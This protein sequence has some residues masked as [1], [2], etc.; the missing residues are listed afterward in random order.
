[1]NSSNS[2][3]SILSQILMELILDCQNMLSKHFAHF[4]MLIKYKEAN[5]LYCTKRNRKKWRPSLKLAAKEILFS[6]I[7]WNFRRFLVRSEFVC[8]FALV[9]P[10]SG[11]FDARQNQSVPVATMVQ[12]SLIVRHGRSIFE[13]SHFGSGWSM[14]NTNDLGLVVFV[15]VDKC[16]FLF[17]LGSI[18]KEQEES[19][20]PTVL[21]KTLNIVKR[22]NRYTSIQKFQKFLNWFLRLK[23]N[24][25]FAPLFVLCNVS[26]FEESFDIW[27]A[28]LIFRL[29]WHFCCLK[30]DIEYW[31]TKLYVG[32]PKWLLHW[33]LVQIHCLLNTCRFQN[34]GEK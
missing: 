23:K 11:A 22:H 6:F 27:D 3:Y 1:M 34:D 32:H 19:H 33:W 4:S 25:I 26:I 24:S 8:G 14:N 18:C 2:W 31:E 30:S 28:S 17:N 15:G 9:F 5:L 16:L 7:T 13:P 21:S 20:K 29:I 10:K 12:N